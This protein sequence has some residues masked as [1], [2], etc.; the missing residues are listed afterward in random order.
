M[1]QTLGT[2]QDEQGRLLVDTQL[3]P[4][5]HPDVSI[6]DDMAH[7]LQDGVPLPGIAPVAMQP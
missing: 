2:G 4:P 5:G 7:R 1:A 3:Q 6:I